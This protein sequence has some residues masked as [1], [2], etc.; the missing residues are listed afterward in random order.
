MGEEMCLNRGF[1]VVA[2]T[3]GGCVCIAKV[4]NIANTYNGILLQ[5]DVNF[6]TEKLLVY[7]MSVCVSF[8]SE[9]YKYIKRKI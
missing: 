6:L 1:I 9:H 7:W 8:K 4:W 3:Y 2:R 5:F